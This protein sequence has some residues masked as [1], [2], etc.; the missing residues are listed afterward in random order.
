MQ[1][2]QASTPYALK[3][4]RSTEDNMAA[5]T[6]ID[7][8]SAHFNTITYDGNSSTSRSLTGVG[9][10]PDFLWIKRRNASERHLL[11]NS[12]YTVE[13]GAYRWNDS[14]DGTAEFS[15]GTGV[16]SFDTDGFTFKGSDA[17]W[18]ASSNTYVA[19]N[20]LASGTTA[21]SN[22]QGDLR[23][24]TVSANTTAGFS[25]VRLLGGSGTTAGHGLGVAPD[26]IIAKRLGATVGWYVYH[27]DLGTG[28]YLQLD[29]TAAVASNS[30]SFNVAP[31][32]TLFTGG[33]NI[34]NSTDWFNFYCF[35]EVQGY[36]KIGKYTGN[37][38]SNKD[39]PFVAT[40]FKPA[41]VMIKPSSG[42][43]EWAIIDAKRN[44]HNQAMKQLKANADSAEYDG[45][46][47]TNGI[48]IL[49]NGFKV[50]TSR[51]E[52]NTVNASYIYLAF[53]EN[54]FVTSTGVPTTA[55]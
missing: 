14:A 10:K 47:V 20:W 31:T 26:L 41:W 49:S 5:Y 16:A 3:T 35:T 29:T 28:K 37:G 13:S 36:S 19:W 38:D 32:S 12:Q 45:T 43:E 25:T 44:P 54:P 51:T 22:T 33:T 42:V 1:F 46:S 24:V 50:R 34:I 8:P 48:D 23:N 18:N 30:D 11:T 2:H 4:W 55:R 17:T 27:K 52:I 9:F 39:G 6:T 15:G 7:D 40:G 53:A 21:A